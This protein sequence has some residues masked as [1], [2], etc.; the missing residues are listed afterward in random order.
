[1]KKKEYIT[2]AVLSYEFLIELGFAGSNAPT[3]AQFDTQMVEDN[4]HTE[5]LIYSGFD[6]TLL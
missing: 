2:P 1:M 6:Y 4:S 3:Q 5:R